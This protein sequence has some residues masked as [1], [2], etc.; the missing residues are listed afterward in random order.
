MILD[1]IGMYRKIAR[2]EL[3]CDNDNKK[4]NQI[5]TF[6]TGLSVHI[7]DEKEAQKHKKIFRIK[8]F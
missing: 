5:V 7:P 4:S 2:G 3:W 1:P 8:S 6:Y